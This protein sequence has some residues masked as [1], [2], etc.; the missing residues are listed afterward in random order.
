MRQLLRAVIFGILGYLIGA[1]LTWLV[2]GG[3]LG[4]EVCV[5]FGYVVG[6]VG[7]LFGIGM[8]DT[9]VR[10]WFGLPARESDVTGWKRYLGFS[11]DHKVIG[12]QYLAT[13]IVVLLLGGVA[14][15]IIRFELAQAG[16]GIL[17]ADRYNQVMSMHGI[18]MVAVAVAAILGSFGNYLVPIMIGAD[19]MAFPRLNA[20][21]FWLI[22]PVAIG[23]LAAPTLGSFDA[24]WTAYPPLSVVNNGGQ[25][26]FVLAVTTFGLSSILGGLNVITTI[27]T[28]RAPGMTW[29]RLPIFVWAA[30]AA[31]MI[32]LLTTQFFAASLVLIAMDRVAGTVFFDGGAGGDPLLYQHLFWFYSHPAVYVMVLP[33]FGLVLETI[34]HMSRKPLFAYKAV[35]VSLLTIAGLSIIVW[36][37]HMFT[38]GMAEYLHGPFMFATEMISVPTGVIFLSAMATLWRGKL[39]MKT[40]LFFA[41]IWIFQFLMGG[42]T[43]IFLADVVTD[44]SLHDSYFVVAHFHYTIMGGMIFAFL[45]GIFFWFPKITGRMINDRLGIIFALWLTIGFQLT[46]L[47]Q[48]WL[49]TNGMNRRIAD[50]PDQLEGANLFSSISAFF[51]GGSFLLLI[52]ILLSAARRG[53]KAGDNPWNASTL[54]WQVSSPPPEHNFSGQPTVVGHPYG[55]G[56]AD[57]RHA[58]F[59]GMT[60]VGLA[61]PEQA[62]TGEGGD[63]E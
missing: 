24:G 36:A 4:D 26:L 55:Y 30:F 13:F 15:M 8:G 53:P 60:A 40:P 14:A 62:G 32:S 50:Y 9:W 28:M 63:N 11:T 34:T 23:L 10:E 56:T 44:V 51:L 16:E 61:E 47:P 19:D 27:V 31:S 43:G 33:G 20:V 39:W 22:P 58:E 42:V 17:N 52:Y 7:W 6:L 38:S 35:V 41:M 57:S 59:A 2:R 1:T 5:V 37:H 3:S 18:L 48:F 25:I 46:F 29:G 54:E 21:T 12:V 49:G 45:T